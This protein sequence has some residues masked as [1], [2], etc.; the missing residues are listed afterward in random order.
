VVQ[1]EK[2]LDIMN[3]IWSLEFLSMYIWSTPLLAWLVSQYRQYCL[4]I[5]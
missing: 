1:K 3:S 2:D 5:K 4:L